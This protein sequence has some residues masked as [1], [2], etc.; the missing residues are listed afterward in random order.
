ML[1]TMALVD[2]MNQKLV[3]LIK[4]KQVVPVHLF[5]YIFSPSRMIF[6]ISVQSPNY[7][8]DADALLC[9]NNSGG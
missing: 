2:E 1:D 9:R 8:F 3:D 7:F 5:L 6:M 4:F